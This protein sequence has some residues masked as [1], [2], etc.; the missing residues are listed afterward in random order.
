VVRNVIGFALVGIGNTILS[1]AVFVVLV[2]LGVHYIPASTAAWAAG[3]ALSFALNKRV[4]FAV[5]TRADP[6][7]LL[8]FAAGCVLQLLLGFA[9]LALLIDGAGLGPTPAFWAT[10][11]VTASFSFA[12]M[13][14]L[15]FGP[16]Q[17]PGRALV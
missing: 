12:F 4:T 7:E 15:V 9:S 14:L 10:L 11:V 1:Y 3:L 2:T 16:R 5:R 6:R 8:W 17:A 13:K